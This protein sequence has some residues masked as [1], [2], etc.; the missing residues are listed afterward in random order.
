MG[1]IK[2][3]ALPLQKVQWLVGYIVGAQTAFV[4][5]QYAQIGAAGKPPLLPPGSEYMKQPVTLELSMTIALGLPPHL[6]VTAA[7]VTE[8]SGLGSVGARAAC[9]NQSP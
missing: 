2:I 6:T 8:H 1:S 4:S 3:L 9:H 7:P 5:L